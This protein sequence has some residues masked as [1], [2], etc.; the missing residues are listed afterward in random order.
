MVFLSCV[1]VDSD[2]AL[3]ST[4]LERV[5]GTMGIEKFDQVEKNS[6]SSS[7]V[8]LFGST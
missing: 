3:S 1:D 6:I 4:A 2:I 5:L 8:K 7:F